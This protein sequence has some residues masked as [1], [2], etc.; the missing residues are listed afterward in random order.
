MCVICR[1][2]APLMDRS[3]SGNGEVPRWR[4][5]KSK[6]NGTGGACNAWT[7][8]HEPYGTTGSPCAALPYHSKGR[9][10][11]EWKLLCMCTVY[12]IHI[13]ESI[14]AMGGRP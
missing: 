14:A 3:I 12:N 4:L 10:L 9:Y 6:S 11:M 1:G 8:G 5:S 7:D 13:H 2:T